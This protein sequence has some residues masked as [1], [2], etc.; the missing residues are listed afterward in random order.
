MEKHRESENDT[1]P[2]SS[3]SAKKT[4][5]DKECKG[6]SNILY[7]SEGTATGIYFF[8]FPSLPS[9]INRWCNLIKRQNNKDG[10]S[11]SSN[12]VLCHHHFT[13][14]DIKKSFLRWKLLPGSFPSQNVS[15]KSTT[16]KQEQKLPVRQQITVKSTPKRTQKT[17]LPTT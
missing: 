11:V 7:D 8:K 12:T 10:F 16:P 3:A 2:L 13:E 5:R 1:Q 14:K 4:K 6:C 17:S 15:G 9:E